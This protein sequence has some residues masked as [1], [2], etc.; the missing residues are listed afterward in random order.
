MIQHVTLELRREDADAE[1]RFWELL[2][3]AAVVPPPGLGGSRSRW[4]ERGGTQVH[5]AYEDDPVIPARGHVA[6]VAPDYERVIGALRAAGH[7]VDP[8]DRALG[9]GARLRALARRP[10]GRGHGRAAAG[11]LRAPGGA[12]RVRSRVRGLLTGG[13]LVRDA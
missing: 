5:L 3:F 2:G 11:G 6:V 12:W 10:H 9:R 8:R 13:T 4:L 7:A 1:Q